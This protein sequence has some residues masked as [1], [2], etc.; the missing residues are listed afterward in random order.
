MSTAIISWHD[1]TQCSYR[2]QLWRRV[3][4]TRSGVC[5]LTGIAINVGD[6][7]YRPGTKPLPR[8][9]SAMILASAIENRFSY[10]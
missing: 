3:V 7:I 2:F 8:N 1:A 9:A 5:A 6:S 10:E 4:S